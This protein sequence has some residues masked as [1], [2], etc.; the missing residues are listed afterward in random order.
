M[1][2]GA[3]LQGWGPAAWLRGRARG[4]CVEMLL[5]C[6]LQPPDL[7]HV[8]TWPATLAQRDGPVGLGRVSG[9]RQEEKERDSKSFEGPPGGSMKL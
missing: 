2:K 5:L 1:G 3:G 6:L 8:P 7:H 4:L 9:C